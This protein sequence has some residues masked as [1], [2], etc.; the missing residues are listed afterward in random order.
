MGLRWSR[1]LPGSLRIDTKGPDILQCRD[2]HLRIRRHDR[3]LFIRMG[4]GRS[5][6]RR[7]HRSPAR[8]RKLEWSWSV[9]S[10]QQDGSGRTRSRGIQG[11]RR[12]SATD[13]EGE[14]GG[15]GAKSTRDRCQCGREGYEADKGVWDQH[16]G[17]ESVQGMCRFPFTVSLQAH[18][19]L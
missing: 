15:A 18:R 10:C 2:P 19:T 13:L 1:S 8:E 3:I 16:L 9:G 4:K 17:R 7:V 11:A 6:F 12:G 14:E 5:V